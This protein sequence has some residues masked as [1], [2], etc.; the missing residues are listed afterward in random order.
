MRITTEAPKFTPI[1]I[2]I[3]TE[4][5]AIAVAGIARTTLD[6]LGNGKTVKSEVCRKLINCL[7]DTQL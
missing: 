3:E 1:V 5:E 6:L 7:K 2:T 4:A